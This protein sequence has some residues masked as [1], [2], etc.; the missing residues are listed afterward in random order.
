MTYNELYPSQAGTWNPTKIS[1][2]VNTD[3]EQ[4]I[5]QCLLFAFTDT[6][7]L[8]SEDIETYM[9]K[10]NEVWEKAEKI[11]T[12]KLSNY[13]DENKNFVVFSPEY[14]IPFLYDRNNVIGQS[15][16]NTVAIDFYV[17][18]KEEQK[19]VILSDNFMKNTAL[20]RAS[21]ND[22]L[23]S[24][25]LKYSDW[26]VNIVDLSEE[27]KAEIAENSVSYEEP[28]E[29]ED[30]TEE[31]P[32]SEQETETTVK[33]EQETDIEET[34]EEEVD[35]LENDVSEQSDVESSQDEEAEEESIFSLGQFV[36]A[37]LVFF[38]VIMTVSFFCA[39]AFV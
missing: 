37:V 6:T 13:A 25:Y 33:T 27:Q 38:F 4:E 3:Y 14:T 26:S 16:T 10:V 34:I 35:D 1:I 2:A 11:S 18:Y 21:Y 24:G 17:N 36:I 7:N 22:A 28:I 31:E 29:T 30:A 19:N 5:K 8:T 23:S 9:P 12:S 20:R 15:L 39:W 32:I